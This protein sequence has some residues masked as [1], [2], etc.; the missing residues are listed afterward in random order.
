M[1][2]IYLNEKNEVIGTLAVENGKAVM[3]G[4]ARGV[5]RA[6]VVDPKTRAK[7][8]PKDGDRWL[9]ATRHLYRAG[10]VRAIIEDDD[11]ELVGIDPETVTGYDTA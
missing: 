8:G 1:R 4:A 6:T 5:D 10:Y 9:H 7:L 3:T 2:L 11:G